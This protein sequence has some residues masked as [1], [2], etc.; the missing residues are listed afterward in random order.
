MSGKLPEEKYE[1][2][3]TIWELEDSVE[4]NEGH[5][6]EGKNIASYVKK[7]PGVHYV[8]TKPVDDDCTGECTFLVCSEH[9]FRRYRNDKYVVINETVTKNE[10]GIYI[11]LDESEDTEPCIDREL[12][13]I[14]RV[15]PPKKNSYVGLTTLKNFWS[16]SVSD[17]ETER[18]NKRRQPESDSADPE[19]KRRRTESGSI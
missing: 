9:F 19:N 5:I 3:G 18:E 15:K 2:N 12:Y 8:S 13:R 10:Q 16:P 14:T 4:L 17:D 1:V 7:H 11:S 6:L